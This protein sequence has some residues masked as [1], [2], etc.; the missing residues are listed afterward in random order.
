MAWCAKMPK[1]H[2]MDIGSVIRE[3]RQ[4]KGLTLEEVAYH[5]GIDGG[6]LSRI[7]RGLQRCVSELMERIAA[8]LNVSVSELYLRAEAGRVD[9]Q[10]QSLQ[11]KAAYAVLPPS[12][13]D[14]QQAALMAKYKKLNG[15]NQALAAEFIQML[16]RHQRQK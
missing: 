8:A 14:A 6:N 16:L 9:A 3:I 10:K 1:N 5:A 12:P 13:E 15:E 2:G 11:I 7:E 4:A